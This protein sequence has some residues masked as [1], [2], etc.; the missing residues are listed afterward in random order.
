MSSGMRKLIPIYGVMLIWVTSWSISV[1][2][3]VMPLY[4]NSLGISE[5]GWGLLV[6]AMAVGM[7]LFEWLWGALSDRG[8]RLVYGTV[9]L[10]GMAVI[11]PLYTFQWLIPYFAVLQFIFGVF[12]ITLG[13]ITRSMVA[14]YSTPG[15]LGM[16]MS[17]WS[18]FMTVG[19]MVVHH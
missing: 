11:F 1:N 4:I 7:V 17:L 19:S 5:Q 2:S 13:P 6:M 10:A 3:P 14:D 18:V 8:N 9:A 15:S 16:T 12:S